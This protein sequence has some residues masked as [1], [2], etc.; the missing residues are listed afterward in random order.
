MKTAPPARRGTEIYEPLCGPGFAPAALIPFCQL[1]KRRAWQFY[2]RD[3]CSRVRVLESRIK[4]L[5]LCET[6]PSTFYHP[7]EATIPLNRIRP[8]PTRTISFLSISK[9]LPTRCLRGC[10]TRKVGAGPPLA[11][12]RDSALR[13]ADHCSMR[14]RRLRP[15][16]Y[17]H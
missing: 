5:E 10:P 17:C 11:V 4:N 16:P 9:Q 2:S 14:A 3:P 8:R 6:S 1:A 15:L 12:A 13:W 7:R